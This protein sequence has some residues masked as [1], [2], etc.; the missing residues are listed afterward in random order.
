MPA[1]ERDGLPDG[2]ENPDEPEGATARELR[3]VRSGPLQRRLVMVMAAN[4]KR[5]HHNRE[6]R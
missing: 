4:T 3:I 1:A 2:L 5:A 6:L